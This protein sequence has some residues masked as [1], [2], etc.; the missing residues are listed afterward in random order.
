MPRSQPRPLL[1]T[2]W[3]VLCCQ[4]GNGK[5]RRPQ[6]GSGGR[7]PLLQGRPCPAV[8]SSLRRSCRRSQ[9]PRG[10]HRSRGDALSLFSTGRAEESSESTDG[11]RA[12]EQGSQKPAADPQGPASGPAKPQTPGPAPADG[13][14]RAEAPG[15]LLAFP[16]GLPAGAEEQRQFLTEQCVA[17]LRLCLGRFPQHYKSLYRLAFL[18][19]HSR[20][21]RVSAHCGPGLTWARA[22]G[23]G[24][25]SR[26]PPGCL[27]P[28]RPPPALRVDCVDSAAGPRA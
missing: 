14:K 5:P 23:R 10:G 13:R 19:T 25:G 16:Q 3:D 9:W 4:G 22:A 6:Q 18:Y 27:Q 28:W 12:T 17:S 8:P 1:H 11:S 15:E 7:D 26:G 2:S 20:T 24:H 21:H